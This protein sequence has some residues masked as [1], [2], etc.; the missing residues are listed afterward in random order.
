MD[1]LFVVPNLPIKFQTCQ[2]VK[3]PGMSKALFPA[4]YS[5]IEGLKEKLLDIY[6]TIRP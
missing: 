2:E 1:G 4:E 5:V 3:F 6:V